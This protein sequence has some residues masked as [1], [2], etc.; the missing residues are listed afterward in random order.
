MDT[1]TDAALRTSGLSGLAG[2]YGFRRVEQVRIRVTSEGAAAYITGT[3][4]RYPHSVRV[5]LAVAA[6]FV[7]AGMPLTVESAAE[8]AVAC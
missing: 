6:E 3:T 2:R 4:H 5:P 7:T 1:V 8:N